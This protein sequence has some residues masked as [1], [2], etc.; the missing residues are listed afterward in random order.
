MSS[1]IAFISGRV[2]GTGRAVVTWESAKQAE[3]L[4]HKIVNADSFMRDISILSVLVEARQ[5]NRTVIHL[6]STGHVWSITPEHPQNY[7]GKIVMTGD[8]PTM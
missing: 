6:P 3:V 7:C 2:A 8:V 5:E 4:K 1:S